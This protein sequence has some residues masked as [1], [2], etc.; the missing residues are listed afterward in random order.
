MDRTASRASVERHAGDVRRSGLQ[1]L[2][3]PLLPRLRRS[4]RKLLWQTRLSDVLSDAPISYSVNGKRFVAIGV[5]NGGSQSMTFPPLVLEIQNVDRAQ[6]I[7]V[8]E[9]P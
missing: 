8:F 9:L 5:G 4:N 6:G 7:W 1:W 2:Y 3:R